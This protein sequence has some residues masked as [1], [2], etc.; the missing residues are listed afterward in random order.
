MRALP[1]DMQAGQA[2]HRQ[3]AP[4]NPVAQGLFLCAL[5]TDLQF[6][7]L[8]LVSTTLHCG[9]MTLATDLRASKR[10]VLAMERAIISALKQRVQQRRGYEVDFLTRLRSH[11]KHH[12]TAAQRRYFQPW[13][14]ACA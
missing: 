14:L 11:R 8:C 3:R 13:A 2:S 12:L 10:R 6:V 5:S 1:R 7:T 4:A 9:V